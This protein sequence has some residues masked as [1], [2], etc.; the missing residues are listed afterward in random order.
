[1]LRLPT[2]AALETKSER[3][4]ILASISAVTAGLFA[5][6]C[7]WLPSLLAAS[8]ASSA[9]L[10]AKFALYRFYFAFTALALIRAAFAFTYRR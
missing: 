2:A 4:D 1:L 6:A 7:C 5:S 3:L 10:S 8:G 9:G